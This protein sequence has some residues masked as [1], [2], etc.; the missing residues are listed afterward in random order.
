MGYYISDHKDILEQFEITED[1]GELEGS[2]REISQK[3]GYYVLCNLSV[4]KPL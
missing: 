4:E 2:K 3:H 1:F